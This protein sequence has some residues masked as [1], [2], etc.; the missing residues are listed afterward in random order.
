MKPTRLQEIDPEDKEEDIQ[1]RVA[2]E[3]RWAIMEIL[4]ERFRLSYKV[5]KPIE[6]KLDETEDL[7]LLRCLV[8]ESATVESP[9]E[10]AAKLNHRL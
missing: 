4:W 9:E 8:V 1:Q 5:G 2:A 6:V 10:F 7:S 3:F